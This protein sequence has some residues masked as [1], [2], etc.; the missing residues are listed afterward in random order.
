MLLLNYKLIHVNG[1][2]KERI[3]IKQAHKQQNRSN[4]MKGVRITGGKLAFPEITICGFGKTQDE[5]GDVAKKRCEGHSNWYP[6]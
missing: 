5:A 3:V 4:T 1:Y 2:L 6:D